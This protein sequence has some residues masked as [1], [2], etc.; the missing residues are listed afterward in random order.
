MQGESALGLEHLTAQELRLRFALKLFAA[1]SGV[2]AVGYVV[3]GVVAESEFPFVAN[4]L[5]KDGFFAL[6][7]LLAISDIR[8]FG[9]AVTLIIVGHLLLW[10][11]LV[12][13]LAIGNTG[14]ISATMGDAAP[15]PTLFAW[16]WLTGAAAV[17]AIFTRLYDS[18]L[19]ARHALHYL[20]YAEFSS[21]AALAE[22]LIPDER[23]LIGPEEVAKNVDDYLASFSARGK[24]KIKLALTALAVYPLLTLR[25][26]YSI[27]S[28]LLRLRFIKRRFLAPVSEC[29]LPRLLRTF[30]Q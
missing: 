30:V 11:A 23:R 25:P 1:M 8:R 13:M 9:Y 10:I 29:R 3:M 19:R 20:S 27:M 24:W 26:V 14:A 7:A 15:E 5:A 6:L 17:V 18:A 12:L 22:V 4:S 28:P 16:L 21:V 2:F